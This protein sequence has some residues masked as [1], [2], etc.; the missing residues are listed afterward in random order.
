M[1]SG[2]VGVGV[3]RCKSCKREETQRGERCRGSEPTRIPQ[4]RVPNRALRNVL[5]CYSRPLPRLAKAWRLAGWCC[6][7]FNLA[8]YS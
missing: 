8:K 5:A 6:A 4:R 2:K 1:D 7:F 3:G